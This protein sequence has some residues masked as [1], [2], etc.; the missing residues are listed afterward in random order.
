MNLF[1]PATASV[2][3]MAQNNPQTDQD[4]KFNLEDE[5]KKERLDK[6]TYIKSHLDLIAG[7][8][9]VLYLSYSVYLLYKK[10]NK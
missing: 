8:F 1:N 4:K 9:L 2:L 7:T 5:D 6:I 3:N 10:N